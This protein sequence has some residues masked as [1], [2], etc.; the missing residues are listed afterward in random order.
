[1]VPMASALRP[2]VEASIGYLVTYRARPVTKINAVW[3]GAR[4][5]VEFPE[6]FVPYSIRHTM[7]TEL[8]SRGVPQHEI[9]VVLGHV[10]P[11]IRSTGRYAKYSPNYLSSAR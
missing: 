3:R 9:A 6:D 2:W 10:M 8:R 1:M 11:N 7:A 4:R 5:A